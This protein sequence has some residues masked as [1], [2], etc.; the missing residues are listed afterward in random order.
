MS[1][2][3]TILLILLVI[4]AIAL[5]GFVLLQHGKGADV[6]AA[7]GSGAANTI[8]G[9]RG[10]ASFLT[11]ATAWLSLGFFVISFLLAYTAKER[12]AGIRD[13][14]LPE[15]GVPEQI[16][17]P[18]VAPPATATQPSSETPAGELTPPEEKVDSDIPDV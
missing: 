10:S 17:T 4:N 2:F 6:G 14:G 15:A 8:F 13:L 9:A 11:K 5:A 7:F 16:D 12:A 1:T 3:E 18:P